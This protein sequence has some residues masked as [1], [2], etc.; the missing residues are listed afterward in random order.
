[1]RLKDQ[2]SRGRVGTYQYAAIIS[3]DARYT[4]IEKRLMKQKG[5]P[6]FR[7]LPSNTVPEA[8]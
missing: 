6:W 1:M 8:Y 2:P 3:A 5:E 4:R 7:R